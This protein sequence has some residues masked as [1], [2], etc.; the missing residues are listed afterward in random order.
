MMTPRLWS[1]ALWCANEVLD[2]RRGGEAPGVQQWNAEL[3]RA[4]EHE[5]AVALAHSRQ[6]NDCCAQSSERDDDDDWVCTADAAAILGCSARTV[7]R[8]AAD[9]DGQLV[10]GQYVFRESDVRAY[11]EAMRNG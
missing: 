9:L 2:A 3:V 6:E 11:A 1:L 10:A 7:Q 4:L 8:R 5:H